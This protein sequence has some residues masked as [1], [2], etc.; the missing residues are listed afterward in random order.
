MCSLDFFEAFLKRWVSFVYFSRRD[1]VAEM[2]I[3]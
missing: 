3:P 2:R 1:E